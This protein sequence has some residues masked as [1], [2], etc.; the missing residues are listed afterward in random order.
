M[1]KYWHFV[2]L[3]GRQ[4]SNEVLE[5]ALQTHPNV[6]II[7]EEYGAGNKTLLD[8]VNDIAD[9]VVKRAS[10]GKNFGSVLI[11]DGLLS[12]LP[13]MNALIQELSSLVRE[14]Q[15]L[16]CFKELQVRV[17]SRIHFFL[18]AR[19]VVIF[20]SG[21]LRRNNWTALRTM[22]TSAKHLLQRTRVANRSTGQ[23]V[24]LRGPWRCSNRCPSSF[25]RN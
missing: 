25:V 16:G 19:N 4:P 12:H 1:P 5:C 6:V 14:T 7:A 2:R 8:V 23:A 17:S 9:L 10:M 13:N 20:A 22:Q 24:S 11:P 21:F 3:M 15:S 18:Y